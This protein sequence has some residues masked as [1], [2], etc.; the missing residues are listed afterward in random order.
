MIMLVTVT[1]ASTEE[2]VYKALLPVVQFSEQS[3]AS[4]NVQP[5]GKADPDDFFIWSPSQARAIS[6]AICSGFDVDFGPD[7]VIA[8]ANT[9]T[10]ADNI[11][12]A[13]AFLKA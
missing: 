10:L 9:R 8:A 1:P 5:E 7:V 3:Y 6:T 2:E 13:K 12:Q 11:V 4:G